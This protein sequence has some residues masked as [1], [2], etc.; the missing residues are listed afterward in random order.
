MPKFLI[1][2]LILAC[3]PALALAAMGLPFDTSET[4]RLGY[5][6][7][8]TSPLSGG[9]T[10]YKMTRTRKNPVT[11]QDVTETLTQVA[12]PGGRIFAL[13]WSGIHHPDLARLLPGRLP[14]VRTFRRGPSTLSTPTL[15]LRMSGTV[16]HSE[17]EAWDPSLVP[18]GVSPATLLPS[19]P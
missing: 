16:I 17:G 1:S 5:T 18:P 7:F 2:L 19:L 11:G 12:G 14:R 9:L 13:S 10:A 6:A 8:S 3:S 4:G 15:V